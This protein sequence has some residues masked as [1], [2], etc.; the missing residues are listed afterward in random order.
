MSI[1]PNGRID[2]I[3]ND[4]RHSPDNLFISE[5]YYSASYDGGLTWTPNEQLSLAWDSLVGRPPDQYKIGDYYH[6]VSD[7]VGANLAYAATFNNEEDIWFLR[8]GDYLCQGLVAE[9]PSSPSVC[10][11]SSVSLQTS[12]TPRGGSITYQWR[13]DGANLADSANIIGTQSPTLV[14]LNTQPADSG[15]YECLLKL[16]GCGAEM[17]NTAKLTVY[18]TNSADGNNDGQVNAKDIQPFINAFVNFAPVSAQLCVYDL[19]GEGIVD[20]SDVAPFVARL[21]GS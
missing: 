7:N 9:Q 13:K 17:T 20:L 8:I 10:A 21:L 15:Y 14:F 2:V 1:S 18:P 4:T 16:E 12:A 5:L 19:T 3:W 11:G 6:M